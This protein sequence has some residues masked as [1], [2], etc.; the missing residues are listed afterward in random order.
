MCL[1]LKRPH[2]KTLTRNRANIFHP[3]PFEYDRLRRSLEVCVEII[4]LG[5][6]RLIVVHQASFRKWS[7][8]IITALWSQQ[9]TESIFLNLQNRATKRTIRARLKAA[10]RPRQACPFLRPWW[11]VNRGLHLRRPEPRPFSRSQATCRSKILTRP[12]KK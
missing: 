11:R 6:C 3:H 12:T 1:R 7:P 10:F 2:E 8:V 5:S 9:V 4:A